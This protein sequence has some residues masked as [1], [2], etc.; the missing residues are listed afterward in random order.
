MSG[1]ADVSALADKMVQGFFVASTIALVFERKGIG[2]LLDRKNL[3]DAVK[4]GSASH[5]YDT[6]LKAPV[7]GVVGRVVG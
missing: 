3:M 6:V 1:I 5:V 7:Q 4:L 2:S